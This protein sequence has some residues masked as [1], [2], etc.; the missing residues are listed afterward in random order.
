MTA[1]SREKLT[2]VCGFAAIYLIWGSTYL[3]LAVAVQ[4]IPPFALMG[5]RS[6]VGGV[7][8]LAHSRAKAD[9]G[10][11]IRSWLRAGLCGVL[12]F[13]GCHGVLAYAEQR[14]PS[15]LAALLLATI[16]FWIIVG[17]SILGRSHQPLVRTILLLLPGLL[18]VVLVAWR[19]VAGPAGLQ[20]SD[21]LLLL[22]ASASWALGTLIA[23]GHNNK[24]SS[25]ALAGRELVT[26]GAAL[27]LLSAARG[28]PIG[29]VAQISLSS[30]LGWSYLTLAGTVVAFGSY[31]WLLKKISPALVATY[32][33]VNPVIAMFLG[34]AF[35]GEEITAT[36]L[37][38]GFLVVA[39]VACLLV[40]NRN[41]THKEVTHGRR[42]EKQQRRSQKGKD[43]G[44]R[45][46]YGTS[47][48]SRDRDGAGS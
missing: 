9:D 1:S 4:T 27:M 33:F 6:I 38:G 23:E 36:T 20:L 12:F 11:S 26:G 42:H 18:G 25:V 3:A 35:L 7:I 15:G 45:P 40:A 48:L 14:M 44:R 31:I 13:V 32:T 43:R 28:E 29:A 17:R 39:S 10:G 24:G 16:P 34:W 47:C 2:I 5:T 21:I 8:L 22:M 41:S 46:T 30:F 37:I 19:S